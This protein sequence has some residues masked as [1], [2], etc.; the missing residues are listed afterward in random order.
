MPAA[1][2]DSDD[3]QEGDHPF[4]NA[5]CDDDDSDASPDEARPVR[6]MRDP[7][8]PTQAEVDKHNITH[9]PFRAWCPACVT[10]QAKDRAHKKDVTGGQGHRRGSF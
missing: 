5:E 10:G 6:V 4:E 1:G 3:E 2:V 8:A 7:G 9:L